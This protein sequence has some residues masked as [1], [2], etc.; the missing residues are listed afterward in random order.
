M[1]ILAFWASNSW[2]EITP[3]SRRPASFDNSSGADTDVPVACRPSSD[4]PAGV[5]CVRTQGFWKNHPDDWPVD[6]LDL[7]A[8]GYTQNELLDI[9]N[10]PVR[11][12]G[13]ISVAY[14]LIAAKLNEA[15]GAP[16]PALIDQTIADADA[17]IGGLVIPPIGS[18]SLRTRDTRTQREL[19][20]DYNNGIADNGPPHCDD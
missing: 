12:N 11:G 2:A 1:R 13:L 14:Q 18:D 7:G 16:V 5:D 8:V 4:P 6:E 15:A 20:D 17:L 19:L 10:E 3:E 9:L